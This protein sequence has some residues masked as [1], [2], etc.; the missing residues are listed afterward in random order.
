MKER[1]AFRLDGDQSVPGKGREALQG[2]RVAR[3]VD[4]EVWS[5]TRRWLRSER[6]SG[7]DKD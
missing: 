6:R 5:S 1:P 2:R 7:C 3:S 4:E